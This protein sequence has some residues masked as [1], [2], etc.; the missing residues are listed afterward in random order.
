MITEK[1][2]YKYP[3]ARI[4]LWKKEVWNLVLKFCEGHLHK[5]ASYASNGLDTWRRMKWH[6]E[7]KLAA[8]TQ[9]YL[10]QFTAVSE[11]DTEKGVPEA[12][13]NLELI[14]K[15]YE[16]CRDESIDTELKMS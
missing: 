3:D 7:P 2:I 6:F 12:L 16:E 4:D 9:K 10:G 14:A 5:V 1:D 8:R 15:Q 13:E 11:V